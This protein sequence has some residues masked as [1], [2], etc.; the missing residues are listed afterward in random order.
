MMKS[1]A[2]SNPVAS[3]HEFYLKK[4]QDL[5]SEN[6]SINRDEL[7]TIAVCLQEFVKHDEINLR[8]IKQNVDQELLSQ[9][10]EEM[11]KMWEAT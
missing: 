7:K 1:V 3:L 9:L 6:L 4:L 5:L 8:I 11:T 2:N 10:H